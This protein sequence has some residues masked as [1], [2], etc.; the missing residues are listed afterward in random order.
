M[1]MQMESGRE[2]GIPKLRE[3][4]GD[5]WSMYKQ[6]AHE[7]TGRETVGTVYWL[8]WVWLI[9]VRTGWLG[10]SFFSCSC[11]LTLDLLLR[12]ADMYVKVEPIKL[13]KVNTLAV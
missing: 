1:E 9:Q 5:S 10:T 4:E 7:V 11:R 13:L 3:R 2:G 6:C 12:D 8:G